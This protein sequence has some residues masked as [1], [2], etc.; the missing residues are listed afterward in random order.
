LPIYA[1]MVDARGW[2]PAAMR[3]KVE[4]FLEGLPGLT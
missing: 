3:Q 1:D 4:Q 2:D